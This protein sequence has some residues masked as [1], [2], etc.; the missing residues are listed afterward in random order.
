M[1]EDIRRRKPANKL[2]DSQGAS[3]DVASHH[4]AMNTPGGVAFGNG[5]TRST[6]GAKTGT[7]AFSF[8]SPTANADPKLVKVEESDLVALR[9]NLR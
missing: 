2:I 6:F 9:E 4:F 5:L 7:H 3:S 1:M 8:N